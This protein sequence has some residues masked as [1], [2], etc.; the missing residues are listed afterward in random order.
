MTDGKV[1]VS[2]GQGGNEAIPNYVS[3]GEFSIG[4]NYLTYSGASPTVMPNQALKWE[5]TTQ[6]NAGL[7]L[8]M[9][10]NRVTFI[11]DFYIKKTSDLLFAVPI[12]ETT[13]FGYITQNIGDIENKGME[14]SVITHNIDGEFQWTTTLQCRIQ[15]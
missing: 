10:N 6:Y 1:R 9:F 7:D 8:A 12:P 4:T 11:T 13:G 15:Q 3:G 5:V 2:V 14:F